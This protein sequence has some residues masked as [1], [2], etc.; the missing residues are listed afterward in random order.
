MRYRGLKDK[1]LRKLCFG[2]GL[3]LMLMFTRFGGREFDNGGVGGTPL[4]S[5]SFVSFFWI[6]VLV[7]IAGWISILLF[8]WN[9]PRNDR[10]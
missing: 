3:F 8:M 9:L 5:T 6:D 10:V 7:F 1:D 4:G 2:I